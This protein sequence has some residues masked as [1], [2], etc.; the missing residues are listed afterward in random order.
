[1]PTELLPT[2][3]EAPA[4]EQTRSGFVLALVLHGLVF[5]GVG[6][7]AYLSHRAHPHFGDGNPIAGSIQASMVNALPLPPRQPARDH[8]VLTSER[9]SIAPTPPPPTPEPPKAKTTP[10]PPKAEPP[11]KP[12]D[13]LIPKKTVPPKETSKVADHEQPTPPKLKPA[14]PPPPT[15]KAT[16]GETAGVQIPQSVSQLKNGTASITI[17]ERAF[18]DRYAYYVKLISQKVNQQWE[19]EQTNVAAGASNG[20]RTTITFTIERD[21]T[22]SEAHVSRKSGSATLDIAATR[23]IQRVEGFGPLPQGNNLTVDFSFDFHSN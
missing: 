10:V 9:P 2:R 15:P 23:S 5:L 1:M 4:A 13:V 18:G 7:A 12:N 6:V 20:K 11:P 17:E 19:Q 14:T 3:N 16:T 21:G 8:E 22:V